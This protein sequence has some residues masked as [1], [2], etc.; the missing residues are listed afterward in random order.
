MSIATQ[1]QRLQNIK[2]AIRSALVYKGISAENHN[3]DD[4]AE[5]IRN[6][7]S[8]IDVS[9]TTADEDSVLRSRIFYSSNGE[10]KQGN[11]EII[12]ENGN[13]MLAPDTL[14]KTYSAGYY[15]YEHGAEINPREIP[16]DGKAIY[17]N[18]LYKRGDTQT[19]GIG[20]YETITPTMQGTEFESGFI[21][22]N[23]GGIA[24]DSKPQQGGHETIVRRVGTNTV[25]TLSD[26]PINAAVVGVNWY[27]TNLKYGQAVASLTHGNAVTFY[28]RT[29]SSPTS[30]RITIENNTAISISNPLNI[31]TVD[32]KKV[33]QLYT[34]LDE[35]YEVFWF[36]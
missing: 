19:Y 25:T 12:P 24:Y 30:N 11:I 26:I 5:D 17:A 31:K 13:V 28:W 8:G 14:S 7:E 36:E 6:I 2:S 10:R 29:G 22:M 18:T 9:D 33:W 3:M 23:T 4:F 32:G 15:P 21:K 34:A 1:I 27:E 20:E 35:D 16:T